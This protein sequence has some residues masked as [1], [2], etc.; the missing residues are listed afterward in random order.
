MTTRYDI[1][2]TVAETGSF[3]R[4]AEQLDYSQSAVSQTVQALE[5]EMGTILFTR[6]KGGVKL[7][8]DGV[9]YLP[10][11]RAICGAEDALARKRR[12]MQGL[13]NSTVRIGTFTS[14][15]RNLLPRLMQQF[16][17][18]YP[19]VQFVLQQGEYT[20]ISQWVREGSID[21]GFIGTQ[22]APGLTVEPLYRDEM[23]AILPPEHPLAGEKKVTL[24]ALSTEPFILLDEGE[25]SVPLEAFAQNGLSPRLAYKVYDDYTILAMVRQ[26]LGVSIL[27]RLV[28]SGFEQDLTLRPVAE[29]LERT[30]ALAW[31]DWDTLPLAARRFVEFIRE[32]APEVLAGFPSGAEN[33]RRTVK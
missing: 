13:E 29:P 28:V 7:T 33:K 8:A 15:S 10:Y 1:V 21:F 32:R 12:E 23:V 9:A 24:K 16:K 25:Q 6:G 4:A 19:G 18:Q 17:E 2:C 3:T 30:V 27:Y 14:V 20:G 5:Q 31:R 11:F 22:T 26:G